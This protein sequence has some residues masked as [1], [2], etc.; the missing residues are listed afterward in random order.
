MNHR[1]GSTIRREHHKHSRSL[2]FTLMGKKWRPC[3]CISSRPIIYSE[4]IKLAYSSSWPTYVP[5]FLV[6]LPANNIFSS[7][8]RGKRE[9]NSLRMCQSHW[10]IELS[11]NKII[12]DKFCRKICS[13]YAILKAYYTMRKGANS[14]CIH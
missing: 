9:E 2:S 14:Y 11:V 1:Q 13:V 8:F 4:C 12:R 6:Q 5:L 10:R 7:N 3:L